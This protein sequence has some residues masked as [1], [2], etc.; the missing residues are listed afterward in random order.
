MG[1]ASAK[2]WKSSYVRWNKET[3][4]RGKVHMYVCTGKLKAWNSSR[5]RS[6]QKTK[7]HVF[8]GLYS[9]Y[10]TLH[11]RKLFSRSINEQWLS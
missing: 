4:D 5:V 10:N 7:V 11:L 1:Q 3:K 2:P 8:V 6:Y 9:I